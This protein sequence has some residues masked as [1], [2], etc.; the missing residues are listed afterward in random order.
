MIQMN[1]FKAE[2]EDLIRQELTAAERVLRSGWYILGNEVRE[3]EASA[4]APVTR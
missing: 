2:P 1:D 3:S 4:S